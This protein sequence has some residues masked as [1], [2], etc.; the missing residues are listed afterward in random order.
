M[1][2]P[3]D[4]VDTQASVTLSRSNHGDFELRVN[5][6]LSRKTIITVKL[7]PKDVADL[8]SNR[9][10]NGSAEYYG[11]PNIGKQLEIKSFNFPLKP[12]A[13]FR[14]KDAAK[15]QVF[16]HVP[17]G[18]KPDLGFSSQDS[19]PDDVDGVKYAKT[20]IIRWV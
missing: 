19:F 15:E 1:I 6:E 10:A 20:T 5:C 13:G 3:N 9:H 17:E 14:D 11:N 4:K 12:G 7:M 18:W 8:V 2:D 16:D